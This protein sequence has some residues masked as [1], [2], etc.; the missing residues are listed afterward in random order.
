MIC[1]VQVRRRSSVIPQQNSL[2]HSSL[3][4]PHSFLISPLQ[5]TLSPYSFHTLLKKE[6]WD[7]FVVHHKCV[8][9]QVLSEPSGQQSHKNGGLCIVP[10][11]VAQPRGAMFH[12]HL[13]LAAH[14]HTYIPVYI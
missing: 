14:L 3:L 2:T 6:L 4:T 13:H 5:S 10:H 1:H 9:Q 8:S 11:E 12:D 7:A